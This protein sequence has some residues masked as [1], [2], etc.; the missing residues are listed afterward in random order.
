MY[1]T[2]I[3]GLHTSA[4]P[5]NTHT[6]ATPPSIPAK[7]LPP[8][9]HRDPLPVPNANAATVPK[10]HSASPN[11]TA[12]SA[13]VIIPAACQPIHPQP[14]QLNLQVFSLKHVTYAAWKDLNLAAP[15]CN[16]PSYCRTNLVLSVR[17][18]RSRA[19][20]CPPLLLS[21]T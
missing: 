15:Y 11:V 10:N 3:L 20:P 18:A 1:Q 6:P 9:A 16:I 2:A 13:D 14:F 12:G 17:A 7:S 4:T 8:K 5:F 21:Q 19:P